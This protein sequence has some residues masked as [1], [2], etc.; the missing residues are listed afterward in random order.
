M[1]RFNTIWNSKQKKQ[2]D[3]PFTVEEELARDIEE[4]LANSEKPMRDWLQ[5]MNQSDSEMTRT[6]E[7]LIDHL[8]NY[9]GEKINHELKAKRNKKKEI[10][11]R[12]P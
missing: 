11:S 6:Q 10:R 7:D 4:E 8:E 1:S 3:I 12:K 2:I 5:K 9:H